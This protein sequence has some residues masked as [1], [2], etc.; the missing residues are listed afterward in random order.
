MSDKSGTRILVCFIL[1]SLITACG[2]KS[3]PAPLADTPLPAT[4]TL[5]P[6]TDTRVPPTETLPPPTDT[7]VPPTGTPV[8]PADAPTPTTAGFVNKLIY[9][10]PEMYS[11]TVQTVEYPIAATF[12]L[13]GAQAKTLPMY[14]FYPP[15]WQ[16]GEMLP[17]VI[18]PNAWDLDEK[19]KW[20]DPNVGVFANYE[21]WG[22]EFAANG[23]ISIA[24]ETKNAND[25]EALVKYIQEKGSEY[26]ID[27]SNLGLFGVSS[28]TVPVGTF[29]YQEGREFIKYA[30]FFYGN[31]ELPDS[32]YYA[33][34]VGLCRAAGCYMEDLPEITQLRRDLPIFVVRT[35]NDSKENLADIDHF[36]QK[37]VQQ[38]LPMTL[39]RFDEGAHGFD[40]NFISCCE[41][42]AKGLEIIQKAIDFMK[43]HAFAE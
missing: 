1:L 7:P 30:V 2:A 39:V 42:K 29:A 6:P 24:Y 38:G 11:V 28:N 9:D 37:A 36:I 18:L 41:E 16:A 43:A 23:L 14:I 27:A 31:A 40:F 25:L 13:P 22:R 10:I 20:P 12:E 5:P 34:T 19:G 26:G 4:N 33:M 3:T 17:A 15:D 32:P 35:G 21:S 8:P